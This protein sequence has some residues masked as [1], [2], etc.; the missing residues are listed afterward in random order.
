[1]PWDPQKRTFKNS[2]PFEM[3]PISNELNQQQWRAL[4][5][6][7]DSDSD[8]GSD[9]SIPSEPSSEPSSD[10][11]SDPSDSSDPEPPSESGSDC[12]CCND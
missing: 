3:T 9:P 10:P 4:D 8:S 11:S 2:N 5:E 12:S 1:M 7:S 6:D